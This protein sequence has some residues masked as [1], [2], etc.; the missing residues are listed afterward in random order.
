MIEQ[1]PKKPFTSDRSQWI[2]STEGSHQRP[3]GGSPSHYEVRRFRRVFRVES[4]SSPE[5]TVHVT[6]DSRYVFYCN[7]SRVG[8][9]PAKGDITH[10]FYETFDLSPLLRD[11]ENVL[12]ALV[13][14]MSR[15]ATRPDA[16]GPPTSVMTYAGGFLLEGEL[17][18]PD[19]SATSLSTDGEWRVSVDRAFHF[20]NDHTTYEGFIGY[21]ERV[22]LSL[23]PDGWLDPGYD[24]TGWQE[25]RPLY[26]GELLETRRDPKSPYG[27]LPRMIPL[28]EEGP[29][30]R[31]AEVFLPGGAAASPDWMALLAGED[32]VEIPARTEVEVILD[33]GRLT[34]AFPT[35]E[36]E[37]GNGAGISLQ[38][39][40]ALRLP[41]GTPGA[42]LLGQKQSLAN[43]ASAFADEST[44]WTFDR[45]GFMTGWH[46][47]YTLSGGVRTIEPFHWRTFRFVGVRIVTGSESLRIRGLHHRFTAYPFDTKGHFESSDPEHAAFWKK[48]LWT[49]R[50][51]SHETYEDGPYY[52]QMQYAGD[53]RITAMISILTTGDGRLARQAL[54]QFD[55]SR[56]PDGLT[57]SRY[58][59]R[60]MQV[61][62]SWSLHWAS[63]ACDYLRLTG[64]RE[65]VAELVTGIRAVVDWFRRRVGRRGLPEDLPYWNTVD[66]CP[67]WQRGQPPGWDE[68]PTCVISSQYLHALRELA[69]LEERVGD[70]GRVSGLEAEAAQTAAAIRSVFWSA[71]DELFRD[72]PGGPEFSQ[73]GNAWAVVSGAADRE[74][75]RALA[76]HFPFDPRLARASFFGLHYVFQANQMLGVY[77]KHFQRMFEPWSFMNRFGLD[78]WAEETSFWRSLCHAWSAH[79]VLEFIRV[80]LGVES[81]ESGFAT[82]KLVPLACGLDHASG[83][84]M[85]PQGPIEV[86]WQIGNGQ[87]N[88]EASLPDGVVGWLRLPGMDKPEK[89]AGRVVRSSRHCG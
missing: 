62:P 38:Y 4:G 15:V 77:E 61:I 13:M 42:E 68:G 89:V 29:V 16:L 2:W 1:R 18:M 75:C 76:G 79:P 65:T 84:V 82:V 40:E 51:C 85:T 56:L 22:D 72:R 71:A 8:R 54:H 63:L 36:V 34:T 57:H 80:I 60:F 7:G 69:W 20:Q 11:G 21:F 50:L 26:A 30:S 3:A 10:H 9:G 28:L 14:D 6:A 27:L 49:M 37:G 43:L 53:T 47:L 86:A 17:R 25:A 45:R 41:W 88:Y 58:P 35:V 59:S 70:K 32:V 78:T 5:L 39:A 81:T 83:T 66:W 67:D 24:E 33:T 73:A 87:F 31:F 23:I 55:W 64:D 52:E 48:S 12:A 74:Q 46:D 19:G 44:S